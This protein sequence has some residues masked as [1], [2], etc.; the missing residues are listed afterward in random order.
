MPRG[1]KKRKTRV[2]QADTIALREKQKK[3]RSIS[4][5]KRKKTIIPGPWTEIDT[6]LEVKTK[7][8]MNKSI[9]GL[10]TSGAYPNTKFY[11]NAEKGWYPILINITSKSI[12][13]DVEKHGLDNYMAACEKSLNAQK[14]LGTIVFLEVSVDHSFDDNRERRFLSCLAKTNKKNIKGFT[15]IRKGVYQV[16]E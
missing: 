16:L 7:L 14:T 6:T 3:E 2:T 9:S 13:R 15:A 12:K 11:P 10:E 4:N 5:Y 8:R 1:K